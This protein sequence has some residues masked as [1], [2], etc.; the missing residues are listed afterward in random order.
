MQNNLTKQQAYEAMEN[1]NKVAHEYFGINEYICIRN[2]KM[3]A[4]DGYRFEKGWDM[5]IE[6]YWKTG[7]NIY[8]AKQA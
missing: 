3:Y 6:D 2:G 1:G 5:R 7:W 4:E 8:N